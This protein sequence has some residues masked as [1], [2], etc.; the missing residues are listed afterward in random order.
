MFLFLACEL[1]SSERCWS[2]FG[3][4][5]R[6]NKLLSAL[7]TSSVLA[8]A[9][10]APAAYAVPTVLATDGTVE[11]L[12][13]PDLLGTTAVTD[14]ALGSLVGDLTLGDGSIHLSDAF[15]NDVQTTNPT[16][17]NAPGVAYTTSTNTIL[18]DL[19]D[20]NLFITNFSFNIGAN[21]AAKAYIKAFYDDGLGNT[22]TT[23][24]FGGISQY[25]TP[26]F[27]VS[28]IDPARSCARITKIEIDP[29]L[30]WGIGNMAGTDGNPC[31]SVP[32]PGTLPLLSTGLLL[33]SLGFGLRRRI[34]NS[35]IR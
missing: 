22:L 26:S 35:V 10:L 18:I 25:S 2:G 11:I 32:E 29:T 6:T 30:V 23:S 20:P 34:G 13:S 3:S 33:V 31:V 15:N 27:S 17:W 1:L 19:L 8:M 12:K 5:M 24:W 4:F 16:W 21:Q 14:S 7:L 28:V 9:A